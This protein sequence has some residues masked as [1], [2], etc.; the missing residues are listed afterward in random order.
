MIQNE[1]NHT[2]KKIKETKTWEAKIET[3]STRY[4]RQVRERKGQNK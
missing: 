3:W 2:R 4:R 1:T